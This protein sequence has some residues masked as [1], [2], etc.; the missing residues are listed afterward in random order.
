MGWSRP[1]A[2]ATL[3]DQPSYSKPQGT[4]RCSF[5]VTVPFLSCCIPTIRDKT[6]CSFEL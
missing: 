2:E 5:D 1:K 4:F 6:L 3:D